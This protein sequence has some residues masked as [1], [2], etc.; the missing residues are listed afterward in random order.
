M[1]TSLLFGS[2]AREVYTYF[3]M[4][5]F[6]VFLALFGAALSSPHRDLDRNIFD[7]AWN[8][9]QDA[10]HAIQDA[11]NAAWNAAATTKDV[12]E[13]IFRC[14][15]VAMDLVKNVNVGQIKGELQPMLKNGMKNDDFKTIGHTIEGFSDKLH[16]FGDCMSQEGEFKPQDSWWNPFGRGLYR[17]VEARA[18]DRSFQ[19]PTAYSLSLVGSAAGS[20]GLG[21]T[22]S[23]E[24]G[25]AI[26][27]S[28]NMIGFTGACGGGDA[29]DEF[30]SIDGSLVFGF[31]NQLSSIPGPS[32]T[33]GASLGLAEGLKVAV[34]V[35]L[36][37][38]ADGYIGTTVSFTI[39][40]GVDDA[41]FPIDF[42]VSATACYGVCAFGA[43]DA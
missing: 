4:R 39:G 3:K 12:T 19:A 5:T 38:N 1:G 8:G 26:D 34:G 20:I 33:T 16:R 22:G 28:G 2:I 21:L 42:M 25:G 37:W 40:E 35:D 15:D 43:C 10:G 11:G 9:I 17:K 29:G 23:V 31:W 13:L 36:V 24:V 27:N 30:E 41:A 7:D 14:K 32:F 18:Y 6:I